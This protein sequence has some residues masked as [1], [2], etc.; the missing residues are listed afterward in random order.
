MNEASQYAET[1]LQN[2][3]STIET[4]NRALSEIPEFVNKVKSLFLTDY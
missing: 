3:S 4:Q 2:L 1:K